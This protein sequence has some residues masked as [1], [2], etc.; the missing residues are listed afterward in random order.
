MVGQQAMMMASARG[1]MKTR[2]GKLGGMMQMGIGAMG[3]GFG[4]PLRGTLMEWIDEKACGFIDSSGKKVFAHKSDFVEPFADGMAPPVGTAMIFVLGADPKS[5]RERAQQIQLDRGDGAG[6]AGF[7][8]TR[9]R[10]SIMEWKQ[11][12]GCGFILRADGKK[13]FAHKSEFAMP[14]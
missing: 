9:L 8:G 5:G 1:G 4:Q 10:G 2:Q 3:Q 12:K 6:I 11:E 7:R 14:F 13:I